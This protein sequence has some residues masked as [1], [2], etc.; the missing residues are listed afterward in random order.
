MKLER[1]SE[2]EETESLD[3]WRSWRWGRNAAD[4]CVNNFINSSGFWTS[5]R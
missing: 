5:D 4:G 3:H 2:W 1:S